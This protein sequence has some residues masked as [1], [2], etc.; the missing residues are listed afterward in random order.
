MDVKQIFDKNN[1]HYKLKYNKKNMCIFEFDNQTLLV[2]I[3]NNK[4]I[5]KI[6]RND[7]EIIEEILLDYDFCLLDITKN[8]LYYMKINE[9]SNQIRNAFNSTDKD[10]IYFGKQV[11]QN[12]ISEK[13]LIKKINKIGVKY[14]E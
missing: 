5:F 8:E 10:E 1:I 3:K 13:D 7:F 6:S 9:P 14:C 11:L 4:N 12:R 2:L